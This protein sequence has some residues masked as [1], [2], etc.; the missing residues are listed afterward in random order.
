MIT[1]PPIEDKLAEEITI[2]GRKEGVE[3]AKK[4]IQQLAVP[5][6]SQDVCKCMIFFSPDLFTEH[7]LTTR[8]EITGYQFRFHKYF[9]E[10]SKESAQTD[11]W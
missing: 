10:S 11:Y 3:L 1:L 9:D 4:R 5:K 7:V 2:Q 6:V 8:H